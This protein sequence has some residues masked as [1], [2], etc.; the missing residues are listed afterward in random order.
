VKVTFSVDTKIQNTGNFVIIKEDHTLGN[1]LRMQLLQA[2]EVS[3]TVSA[4]GWGITLC[5]L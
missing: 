4:G 1:L 3:T 2:K 5:R